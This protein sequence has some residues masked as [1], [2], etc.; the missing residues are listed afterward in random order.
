VNNMGSKMY[1]V[2]IKRPAKKKVEKQY[3]LSETVLI[4]NLYKILQ[5]ADINTKITIRVEDFDNINKILEKE[6]EIEFTI[7]EFQ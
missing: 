7:W 6:K 2:K 3:F 5:N 4:K 1:I